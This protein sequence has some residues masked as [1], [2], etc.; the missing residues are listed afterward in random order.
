MEVPLMKKK[1]FV[2]S[3]GAISSYDWTDIAEGTGVVNFWGLKM[4]DATGEVYRI[5]TNAFYSAS[6]ETTESG[7]FTNNGVSTWSSTARNFDLS[8]FN[9]AKTAR[10]KA[11]V[12]IYWRNTL[13]TNTPGTIT[14]GVYKYDGSTETLVGSTSHTSANFGAS[15]FDVIEIALTQ[16]SFRKGD[17]L[18]LKIS[19]QT[20]V[21]GS[22]GTTNCDFT[23]GHD[24]INRDGAVIIPSADPN[25]IT[26][27][28]K[29]YCPFRIE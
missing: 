2:R 8:P 28:L 5:N 15:H 16:T 27:Q 25:N 1:S 20:G 17:L 12:V 21:N 29:F 22:G 13:S 24:P 7:S 18:R 26:T 6:I 10:G 4:R 9:F 19:Y 23:F 11:S 14:V 3:Q